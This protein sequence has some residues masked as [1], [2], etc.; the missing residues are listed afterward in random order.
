M[1]FGQLFEKT[2][3]NFLPTYG[4]T[5]K[6]ADLD[7][8][9]DLDIVYSGFEEG[10][11]S[12]HTNVY[13]NSNGSFTLKTTA[14]PDIRNGAFAF[15]DY[16]LD[17]DLDILLSGFSENGNVS[18][19]YENRGGFNFALKYSFPGLINSHV[20]W[21]DIDNDG[22][23]DFVLTGVDDNSGGPD[24]FIKKIFAYENNGGA[25]M[26]IQTS[27]PEC[28]QCAMDWADANGDGKIDV[29]MTGF[30]GGDL[31]HTNLYLNK[32]D[33]TFQ[34]DEKSIFKDLFNGDVKW[35]DFDV[36]GD[37]DLLMSGA[38]SDG[39]FFT[40]VYENAK[41]IFTVRENLAIHPTAE[42]WHGGTAWVD[43]DND[44]LLDILV[45]GRGTSGLELEYILKLYKNQGSGTFKEIDELVFE[46]LSDSSV[47]FGDFDNDGDVDLC[48]TGISNRGLSTGI[49]ENGI[50]DALPSLN[51]IP[52]P[53]AVSDLSENF[54][55]KETTLRWNAGSDG[56][57]PS[58]ALNYN[59]YLRN[60]TSILV[61][62]T[63]H[64]TTGFL[65]T[66]NPYNGQVRRAVLYDM[67]EGQLFWS[68]QAI[69]GGKIGSPFTVEKAFYHINGPAAVTAEILDIENV[70]LSWKDNSDVETAYHVTRS[71]D[72]VTGFIPL[73]A[74]PQNTNF[75]IDNEAFLT[76]TFYYYRI[77]AANATKDSPYDSLHVAIPG[78]PYNLIA[79]T[80]NASIINVTWQHRTGY[81]TG[82]V[83][84][85]KLS[86]ASTYEVV[87]TLLAGTNFYSDRGLS[88]G[89]V[90]NYRVRAINDFGSSAFSN[91]A[92]A[93]TNVK[94]MGDDFE[95][96]M[97]E[98]DT[99]FF[100]LQDF[101][102]LFS[103]LDIGDQLVH[104]II[105]TLPQKGTLKLGVYNVFQGQIISRQ[106]LGELK[107]VGAENENGGTAFNF[108]TH[109]GKD[110]SAVSYRVTI[111]I[112]PVNDAPVLSGIPDLEVDQYEEI[113]PVALTVSDVDDPATSITFS[114]VSDNQELIKDANITFAGP[115]TARTFRLLPQPEKSGEAIVTILASDEKESVS[116]QFKLTVHP[117][118]G[119]SESSSNGLN[120]FPNPFASKF[121]VLM[122]Q[123]F[124]SPY[125]VVLYD[126]RG[127][128]VFRELINESGYTFD[129]CDV[130]NGMYLLTV[131]GDKGDVIFQSRVVKK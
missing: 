79:E 44:G 42:N 68:A 3:D 124:G 69:D 104:I 30:G 118:T 122:V 62:P 121:T 76:N 96:E 49:Y 78:A 31:G 100:A 87:V 27:L 22:D 90:Y 103:D 60:A 53:P 14:L 23:V 80:V 83:V 126:L 89:T 64:L 58:A 113:I 81:E 107:F 40:A 47:D 109:D 15:G 28:T 52:S 26:E 88:E 50:L 29:I 46:G 66:M 43:Y 32:G 38:A 37:M 25:F 1:C 39:A 105:E 71:L 108:Y 13:E 73:V 111:N 8:D 125:T 67:P 57:T 5:I 56:E 98:D 115:T 77:H 59:F 35:G 99:L 129:V 123:S 48:F 128:I 116:K 101:V 41:G 65:T 17:N 24:P 4:G 114:G 94:P 120:I 54:F 55:R 11:N 19:L 70:R 16:D 119:I 86:S 10:A 33:K 130:A 97:P 85:R 117:V 127:R 112:I 36:D 51:T 20:S 95:K 21:F 92:S 91:T 34:K 106:D 12:F 63:S 18:V 75:Y 93:R 45:S 72:S 2:G 9:S 110:T 74:L 102:G 7:K 82:Y 61:M 131:A 6:W 84:E